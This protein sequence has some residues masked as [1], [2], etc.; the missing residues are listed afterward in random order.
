MKEVLETIVIKLI[1]SRN[2]AHLAH[3]KAKTYAQHIALDEYYKGIT[4]IFD[5]LVESGQGQYKELLDI[6]IIAC[7]EQDNII[8]YLEELY[9]YIDSSQSSLKS[10]QIS[11]LDE[12]C[13]LINTTVYKLLFLK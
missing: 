13:E 2:I 9:N 10:Y 6:R 11:I 8:K 7:P 1:Q 3:F 5:R 12:A 4:K